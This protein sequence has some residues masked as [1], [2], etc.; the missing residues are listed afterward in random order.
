MVKQASMCGSAAVAG[1]SAA[2][3]AEPAN[4]AAGLP[5]DFFQVAE[6]TWSSAPQES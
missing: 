1:A 4:S 6:P 5:A 3:Q 2:A